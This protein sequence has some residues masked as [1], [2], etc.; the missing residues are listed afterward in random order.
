[1]ADV[2]EIEQAVRNLPATELRRFRQWFAAFDSEVWD[3]QI[4]CDVAAGRL[5]AV[6]SGA[7]A[8]HESGNSKEL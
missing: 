4:E 2:K 3:E 5:D 1:M 8:D 6:A 7:V